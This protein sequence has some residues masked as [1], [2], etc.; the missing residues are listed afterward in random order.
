MSLLVYH[1]AIFD[2]LQQGYETVTQMRP[3]IDAPRASF[4]R[5]ADQSTTC[6][7]N[8]AKTRAWV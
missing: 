3:S 4:F 7:G 2:G 5:F 1:S 6:G 8:Y